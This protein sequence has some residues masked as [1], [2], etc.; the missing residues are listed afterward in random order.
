MQI[1]WFSITILKEQSNT[2]SATSHKNNKKYIEKNVL[3]H[4]N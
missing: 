3:Y 2:E 1:N 4:S